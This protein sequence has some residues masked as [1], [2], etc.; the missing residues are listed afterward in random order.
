MATV[1]KFARYGKKNRPFYRIVV[2]DS[3]SP[4]DGKH[5]ERLGYFDPLA[6][7]K[8]LSINKVRLDYWLSTGANM[9]LALKNRLKRNMKEVE[10]SK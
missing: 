6:K 2:Q 9:S 7:D 1:I 4:R 5:I 3:R 10:S 8:K